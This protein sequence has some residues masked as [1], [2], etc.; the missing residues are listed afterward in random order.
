[1]INKPKFSIIKETE[2]GEGTIV[3]DHVNLYKCKIGIDIARYLDKI[4]R[5]SKDF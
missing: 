1:M 4:D 3:R 2:I 5:E